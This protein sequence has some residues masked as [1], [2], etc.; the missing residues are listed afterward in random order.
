M[1]TNPPL[2]LDSD[3]NLKI[4]GDFKFS[5]DN[6]AT[7]KANLL[8]YLNINNDTYQPLTDDEIKAICG[9]TAN[10]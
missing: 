10:G 7:C 8:S 4:T 9:G 3:G 6:E 2:Q 5:G 1:A